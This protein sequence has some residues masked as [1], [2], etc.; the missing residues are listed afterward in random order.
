MKLIFPFFILLL[1]SASGSAQV[2]ALNENFDISCATSTGPSYP[3]YWSGFC[4]YSPASALGWNCSPLGGRGSTPGFDCNSYIAGVHYTDTAWL[5][6]PILNLSGNSENI[7]IRYDS[8]YEF[9]ASK[10]KVL[11]SSDYVKYTRPDSNGVDWNEIST[12]AM[13]EIGHDDSLDWVTHFIDL[14]SFKATPFIVAFKY[15]S[16]NV[17]GGRWTIDNIMTTPWGLNVTNLSKEALPISI[18]GTPNSSQINV[19][20]TFALAGAYKLAIYDLMGRVAYSQEL[21]TRSGTQD[22][23]LDGLSLNKGMYFVKISNNSTYGAAKAM[24]E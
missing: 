13:P 4:M 21:H 6:T 11:V 7:F 12:T 19:S 24:V 18:L 2:S 8:K 3:T 9:A 20:C 1:I 16:T 17:S 15:T 10:L 5:F 22:F 23:V 14:T